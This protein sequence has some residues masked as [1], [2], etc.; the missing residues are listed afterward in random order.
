MSKRRH[1]FAFV[2]IAGIIGCTTLYMLNNNMCGN[3]S[4]GG[5]EGSSGYAQNHIWREQVFTVKNGDKR[6]DFKT[7][8]VAGDATLITVRDTAAKT[9]E[10]YLVDIG[11][12]DADVV[13]Y[14][15][16]EGIGNI[17]AIILTNNKP[18]HAGGLGDL[19]NS[20]ITVNTL[21]CNNG[22]FTGE[23]SKTVRALYNNDN[24]DRIVKMKK[25]DAPVTVGAGEEVF[26]FVLFP[27]LY[28]EKDF[29]SKKEGQDGVSMIASFQSEHEDGNNRVIFGS[30]MTSDMSDA[31]AR[32]DKK[33]SKIPKKYKEA[34]QMYVDDE[35][36]RFFTLYKVARHAVGN[37][38]KADSDAELADEKMIDMT[39]LN[40]MI[41]PGFK[42]NEND[43]VKYDPPKYNYFK[44]CYYKAY[45]VA[46]ADWDVVLH[47]RFG[48][49]E[50]KWEKDAEAT[51]KIPW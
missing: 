9:L 16:E 35:S 5:G 8:T 26:D 41:M 1:F 27:P 29:K 11:S 15:R 28:S 3:N 12:G 13:K 39:Q 14:L 21:Y 23:I 51:G 37:D 33:G 17:N 43:R 42:Y 34:L 45:S 32:Y 7:L 25:S 19:L 31:L 6:T 50:E 18:E 30:D 47:N 4:G 38:R 10:Y 20:G 46:D 49:K 44:M 40:T 36:D 22:Y 48:A 2:L 24:I